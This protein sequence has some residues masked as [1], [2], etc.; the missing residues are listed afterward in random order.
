MK[1]K[2]RIVGIIMTLLVIMSLVACA[3]NSNEVGYSSN[4]SAERATSS[5]GGAYYESKDDSVNSGEWLTP[6]MPAESQDA[7]DMEAQPVAGDSKESITPLDVSDEKIIRK[8]YMRIET[9]DFD[10]FISNVN[11]SVE[12]LGGYIESADVNGKSIY[13]YDDTRSAEMI[14]RIPRAKLN[15]FMEQVEG[16]ANVTS[17]S[18]STENVTLQYVDTESRKKALEIEQERLF[19]ILEKTETL[20]DIFTLESRLSSIRYELQNFESKIRTM[21]NQVDYSTVTMNINEVERIT[22][23]K[24]KKLTMWEEI[25][26]QYSENIYEFKEGSK[27]FFIGFVVNLPYI[28]IWAIVLMVVVIVCRKL[29]RK[30]MKNDIVPSVKT[31]EKSND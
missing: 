3:K 14:V 25:R 16:S 15:K 22:P 27:E 31:E 26:Q 6:A 21:D 12:Y 17:K 30:F 29:Y 13:G 18:E 2:K 28:L 9:L 23:V 4:K 8:V 24:E 11:S 7:S 5:G 19:A 1:N 10:D 20:Q